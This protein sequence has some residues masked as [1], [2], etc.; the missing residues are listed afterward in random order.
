MLKPKLKHLHRPLRTLKTAKRMVATHFEM[1]AFADRADRQF[2]DDHR[3]NL[4]N[5]TA[6]FAGRVDNNADDTA[7]L[8]RICAAYQATIHHPGHPAYRVTGWWQEVR[9]RSLGPVRK[10]LLMRDIAA[11]RGMYANFFRDACSAGLISVPYGMTG[12]YFGGKMTDLH[13]RVYLA[14]TLHR[15]N[16]WRRETGDRFPLRDLA[17]PPI[18]NPFG[19]CLQGTLVSAHAEFHHHCADRVTG[20]LESDRSMVVEIGGGFGAMAYYLLRG[21][22]KIKYVDFDLPES[23]ALATYYLV[24]AFPHKKFLL[25]GETP[26]TGEA[27]DHAD[28]ALLPLF[29]ME[30]LRTASVDVAFSSHAM[31]DIASAELAIY[32]ETIHRVT[33]HRFLFV[34]A[35][36]LPD[37]PHPLAEHGDLFQL[38]EHRRLRWS[39]HWKLQADETETLYSFNRASQITGSVEGSLAHVDR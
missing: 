20:L 30:Q 1:R 22:P 13:R 28:V 12:A 5:V 16:Y 35:A 10:A 2:A 33:R 3:Y 31:S 38:E 14:D 25:F 17:I 9:N 39:S 15:L 36:P 11:L 19:V 37:M 27:I 23:T 29:A 8:Q 18:G 6:G 32:L 34:R 7:L 21:Q 24:K 4:Q 26:V